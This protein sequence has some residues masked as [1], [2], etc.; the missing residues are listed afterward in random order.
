MDDGFTAISHPARRALIGELAERNDQTLFELTVRL[1]KR[2]GLPLTRQAVAKH[3]TVLKDA[4]VLTVSTRGRTTAHHLHVD[5]LAPVRDWLDRQTAAVEPRT[6]NPSDDR[7][8][9]PREHP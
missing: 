4:G 9:T 5:A 8:D 3:V 2:H 7:T 1:L 6:P